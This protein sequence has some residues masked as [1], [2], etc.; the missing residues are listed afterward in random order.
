MSSPTLE[1]W[2]NITS[3]DYDKW[4]RNR[5]KNRWGSYEPQEKRLKKDDVPEGYVRITTYCPDLMRYYWKKAIKEG[6]LVA[7]KIG[8]VWYSMPETLDMWLSGAVEL[9]NNQ[10][11]STLGGC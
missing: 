8:G 6:S 9:D 10:R 5:G 11:I 7:I 2:R 3:P 1:S 4:R